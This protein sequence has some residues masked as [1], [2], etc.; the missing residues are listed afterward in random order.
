MNSPLSVFGKKSWPSHGTS[1]NAATHSH[2]ENGHENESPINQRGQQKLIAQAQ[3]FEA[4]FESALKPNQ[5]IARS[6]MPCFAFSRYIASVGTSVRER[7]YDAIMANTTASAS[8]TN[9]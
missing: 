6:R 4:P 1:R 3:T 8:G 5:W 2:E 7:M 9:R